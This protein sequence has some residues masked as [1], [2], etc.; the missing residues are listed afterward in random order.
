[1]PIARCL[2]FR[3]KV[4]LP[5]DKPGGLLRIAPQRA[6]GTHVHFRLRETPEPETAL[7]GTMKANKR[8]AM[9]IDVPDD[10]EAIIHRAVAS[11]AFGSPEEAVRH[12]LTLL[13]LEQRAAVAGL[14]AAFDTLP[15]DLDPDLVARLQG[16]GAIQNPDEGAAESWPDGEDFDQW[17]AD[18]QELRGHGSPREVT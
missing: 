7:D 9:T 3:L 4:K 16:I 17:L 14:P 13:E 5:R 12:A 10:F 15:N 18:L 2:F 11:G 8:M 1:M 6:T